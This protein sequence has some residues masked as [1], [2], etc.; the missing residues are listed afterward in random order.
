MAT[1]W[2]CV[3]VSEFEGLGVMPVTLQAALCGLFFLAAASRDQIG[4]GFLRVA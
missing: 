4:G 3:T 1:R 2:V